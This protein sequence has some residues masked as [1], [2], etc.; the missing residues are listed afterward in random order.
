[1]WLAVFRPKPQ[2]PPHLSCAAPDRQCRIG[3]P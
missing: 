3:D 2:V 1:M